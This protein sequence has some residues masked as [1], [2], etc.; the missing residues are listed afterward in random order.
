MTWTR[1]IW[2]ISLQLINFKLKEIT[3]SLDHINNTKVSLQSFHTYRADSA[4][5]CAQFTGS[6]T[7]TEFRL[8]INPNN[9]QVS[10]APNLSQPE[11]LSKNEV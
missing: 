11:H 6:V 10:R 1:I 8:A 4:D 7:H 3:P 5:G 9:L 2:L